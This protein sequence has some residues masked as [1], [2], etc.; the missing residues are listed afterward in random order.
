MDVW[1]SSLKSIIRPVRWF[2]SIIRQTSDAF[3]S[4]STSLIHP[5]PKP[6]ALLSLSTLHPAHLDLTIFMAP[7]RSGSYTHWM[8]RSH[9]SSP[10]RTQTIP[11]GGSGVLT[12]VCRIS[13]RGGLEYA[14]DLDYAKTAIILIFGNIVCEFKTL[15]GLIIASD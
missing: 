5:S 4:V 7:C 6:C 13:G 9:L 14:A 3:Y 1:A 8:N 10:G 11:L 12:F 2:C 15:I